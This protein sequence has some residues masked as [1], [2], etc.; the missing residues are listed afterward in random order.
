MGRKYKNFEDVVAIWNRPP[1]CPSPVFPVLHFEIIEAQE[2]RGAIQ[3]EHLIGDID[4]VGYKLDDNEILVDS[5]GRV[6]DT[7]FDEIVIPNSI[8][9]TW[10]ETEL[11]ENLM[12]AL[13]IEGNEHL[14][15]DIL[16]EK[17]VA[18]IVRKAAT[19]F[20]W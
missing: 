7:M 15:N 5:L 3:L 12:P 6:F 13:Q 9:A 8:I 19:Y 1:R 4:F 17:E 11:K 20:A 14:T 18:A 2:C 16:N 10:S